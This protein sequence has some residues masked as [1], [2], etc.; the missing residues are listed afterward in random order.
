[1][2]PLTPIT[3]PAKMGVSC[4]GATRVRGVFLL[5]GGS[6]TCL[7][8]FACFGGDGEGGVQCE[9]VTVVN[10]DIANVPFLGYFLACLGGVSRVGGK[11][12]YYR[13]SC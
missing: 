8:V 12:A 13:C 2:L 6:I 9:S 11:K 5:T 10:G 4:G 3:H 7:V 1:M